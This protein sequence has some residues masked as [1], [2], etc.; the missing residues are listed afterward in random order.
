[1]LAV[2]IL[3]IKRDLWIYSIEEDF[4]EMDVAALVLPVVRSYSCWLGNKRDQ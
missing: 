2:A 3:K 4:V 1:M